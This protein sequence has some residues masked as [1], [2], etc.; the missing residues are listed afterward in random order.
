MGVMGRHFVDL[1]E[2]DQWFNL[3]L[4]PFILIWAAFG[5]VFSVRLHSAAPPHNCFKY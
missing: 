1:F 3:R 2:K 5:I 4:V